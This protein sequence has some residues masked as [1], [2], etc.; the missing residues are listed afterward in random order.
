MDKIVRR[1]W[2]HDEEETVRRIFKY[3]HNTGDL[4]YVKQAGSARVGDKA[5]SYDKDGYL[6][7]QISCGKARFHARV[8]RICW[9]LFYGTWPS[10]VDH[11]DGDKVNNRIDNMREAS[12]SENMINRKTFASNTSGRKGVS[13]SSRR[14]VYVAYI[15]HSGKRVPLGEFKDFK[16]ACLA[17]EMA[18]IKFHGEFIHHE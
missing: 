6:R 7:V 8:H 3:D 14:D 4:L 18:E 15:N 17:R 2:S 5:G 16:S 11:I 12:G 9:F 1:K 10:R 13:Y